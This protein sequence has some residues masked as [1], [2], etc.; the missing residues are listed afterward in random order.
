[1]T[2]T[3][4]FAG[5]TVVVVALVGYL[6][7]SATGASAEYYQTIA[8]MRAHPA[9]SDVRVLGVVQDGIQRSDGGLRVRF[10]A[11]DG[12]ESMPV[13]YSGP[14][15]DIFKPGAHVVV[16]GRLGAD[17]VFHARTLQTKCPSRFTA[18]A[19]GQT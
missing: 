1:M 18:R 4:R 11:S 5:L 3:I 7:Y 6:V 17:G 13:D 10:V 9:S 12:K 16:D 2:S 15:P 19:Q 14:L 8:E